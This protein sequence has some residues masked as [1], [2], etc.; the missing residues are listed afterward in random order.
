MASF[1]SPSPSSVKSRPLSPFVSKL[2]VL[3]SETK[4]Q[5]AIRWSSNGE[6]IVIFDADTFK[7]IVLDKTA[8]MFKTKNFTSFVRQLNLYGFRKV[9]TNGKS[10]P[11]KNMKFEHP[12]FVQSKPQM[13][14]LVQRTCS[15][16]KKRKTG[17]SLG[18]LY[19]NKISR[20]QQ[21]AGVK[22]ESHARERAAWLNDYYHQATKK[23]ANK[24]SSS[25]KVKEEQIVHHGEEGLEDN[26][27]LALEYMYQKFKEEQHAVQLLMY[28]KYSPPNPEVFPTGVWEPQLSQLQTSYAMEYTASPHLPNASLCPCFSIPSVYETSETARQG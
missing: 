7:R 9:P 16:S 18:S 5:N 28:L 11:N 15:S 19:D 1:Q 27:Q 26:E 17:D 23:Q 12:H 25:S 2:K 10:D 20:T 14:H 13:M 21:R 8:E 3:L 4:Y 22:G 24:E 6:A